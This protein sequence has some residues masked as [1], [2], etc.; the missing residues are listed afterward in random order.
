MIRQ[1]AKYL[2][3][4]ISQILRCEEWFTVLF[5]I[6][7]GYRPT[8]VSKKILKQPPRFFPGDVVVSHAGCCYEV[9]TTTDS[10]VHCYPIDLT[11]YDCRRGQEHF[12]FPAEQLTIITSSYP[13]SPEL[14]Q[15]E[16]VTTPTI[17]SKKA[18]VE[19]VKAGVK[20]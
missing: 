17:S 20:I 19:V 12:V 1:V 11:P 18:R 7:K 16:L 3:V 15:P 6:A 5:V 13:V 8:F 14:P 10:G 9:V 4:D 2:S